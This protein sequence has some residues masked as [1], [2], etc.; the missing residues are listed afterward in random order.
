MDKPKR[1]RAP[2]ICPVCGEDVPPRALA[3]PGCGADHKSGW[4]DDAETYDGIDLGE[5][6]FNYNEFVA[7][8]FGSGVKPPRV[9]TIWWITAIALLIAFAAL[10]FYSR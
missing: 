3:C 7:S 1:P 4:R 8:E 5:E 2:E 6:D 9:K 10:Y